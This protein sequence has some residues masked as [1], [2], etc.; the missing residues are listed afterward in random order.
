M[1]ASAV[2][3]P[4]VSAPTFE[5]IWRIFM[6][7][8]KTRAW[9]FDNQAPHPNHVAPAMR[10]SAIVQ[11]CGFGSHAP[12]V[13]PGVRY[14]DM[15]ELH[16]V[17]G[18]DGPTLLGLCF[19]F[20]G[21]IPVVHTL[22]DIT[23]DETLRDACYISRRTARV[24]SPY[25]GLPHWLGIEF[26]WMRSG[27]VIVHA[28]VYPRIHHIS[29]PERPYPPAMD[30]SE[31]RLYSADC[32]SRMQA[33]VKSQ[34]F[35]VY[36]D[37][38]ISCEAQVQLH[39]PQDDFYSSNSVE[40]RAS[41]N[42]M[43]CNCRGFEQCKCHP[44]MQTRAP[45]PL[46]PTTNVTHLATGSVSD[47]HS[48]GFSFEKSIASAKPFN[49]NLHPNS[50]TWTGDARAV[51]LWHAFQSDMRSTSQNGTVMARLCFRRSQDFVGVSLIPALPVQ[52]HFLLF[53]GPSAQVGI[54]RV[55]D[56]LGIS[57]G[58]PRPD[59]LLKDQPPHVHES[60]ESIPVTFESDSWQTPETS[61]VFPTEA[62]GHWKHSTTAEDDQHKLSEPSAPVD[63][64][65]SSSYSDYVARE[66][67]PAT[68][69]DMTTVRAH[70]NVDPP[71]WVG[72]DDGT[73][74][75][76]R[77][78]EST[79]LPRGRSMQ[80]A[81]VTAGFG[82]VLVKT[83]NLPKQVHVSHDACKDESANGAHDTGTHGVDGPQG[84]SPRGDSIDS[85]MPP[86]RPLAPQSS[87]SH[88]DGIWTCPHCGALV[89]GKKGNLNRH[90]AN[91]H[92]K[93]RLFK[94]VEPGCERKFQTKS[95]LA[96]HEKS[97][98]KDRRYSCTA[99]PRSFKSEQDI[100][101]HVAIAH[102]SEAKP[103]ACE[104]CGGCF[105]RRSE[106]NRHMATVHRQ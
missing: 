96:R 68:E 49:N 76:Q 32:A 97:V 36:L 81:G 16:V 30:H 12:R 63:N 46:V 86:P 10:N 92:E 55:C 73:G 31:T 19:S 9:L 22:F 42:C 102:S 85:R 34:E 60:L 6:A 28:A 77:N 40:L 25:P 15:G 94:C 54:Q 43:F 13:Y 3:G 69:P 5:D 41:N 98:H 59:L 27:R 71:Q 74:A 103:C 105:G 23:K 20:S 66:R 33:L 4:A 65:P 53:D 101:K 24:L 90:V 39:A 93:L 8:A 87:V 67:D 89:R 26:A 104:M 100:V 14:P 99:C 35:L 57:V 75:V 7:S 48:T 29:P 11:G 44:S 50:S 51:W 18:H 61:P 91:M 21:T 83:A 70:G 88:G 72:E 38:A 79:L 82:K 17:A 45:S 2:L 52:Y 56:E 84:K 1:S 78:T 95:N 62:V 58:S 37:P 80:G 106:L 47:S 64:E